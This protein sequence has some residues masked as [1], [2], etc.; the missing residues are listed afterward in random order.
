MIR[1]RYL[2]VMALAA[3]LAGGAL[4][5]VSRTAARIPVTEKEWGVTALPAS[6]KAGS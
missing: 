5:A 3:I 4:A 6:A 2:V 1:L